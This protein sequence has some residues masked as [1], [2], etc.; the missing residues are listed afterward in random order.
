MGKKLRQHNISG[1]TVL[2][3]RSVVEAMGGSIQWDGAT[4]KISL[5]AKGIT[6]EMWIDKKE[7]KVNGV[8][9]QMDVAP[10]ILNGNSKVL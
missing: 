4:Q 8:A 1:R 9:K 10:V 3:I 7:I 2:P 5:I 6:V